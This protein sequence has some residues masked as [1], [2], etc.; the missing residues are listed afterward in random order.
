MVVCQT[1]QTFC[2]HHSGRSLTGFGCKQPKTI[3]LLQMPDHHHDRMRIQTANLVEAC[4]RQIAHTP[5]AGCAPKRGRQGQH[6]QGRQQPT[7]QMQAASAR[8][9]PHDSILRKS[10]S[11]GSMSRGTHEASVLL[12][13]W[14]Q[15]PVP[16]GCQH[17]C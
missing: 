4:P 9:P 12:S 10:S 1:R 15:M 11:S 16:R 3:N 2:S 14:P 8:G 5:H 6:A 13:A 17:R 7:L